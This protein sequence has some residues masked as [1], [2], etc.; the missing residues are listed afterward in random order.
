MK[1]DKQE[2]TRRSITYKARPLPS[3]LGCISNGE[4]MLQRL[5]VKKHIEGLRKV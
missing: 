1:V 5:N 3:D 4:E 2:G